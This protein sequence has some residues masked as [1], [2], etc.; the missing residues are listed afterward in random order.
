[1]SSDAQLRSELDRLERELQ[2]ARAEAEDERVQLAHAQ[3]E[4]VGA[5][6]LATLGSLVAG[7][8]H[9]LNTPLGSLHSNHDVL[10]RALHR[11]QDVLADEKVDEHELEEVRRIV[12]AL[13][14]VMRVNDLAVERMIKLVASLRTFGRPDRSDR[15]L[16]DVHDGIESALAILSHQLKDRITVVRKYGQLP[17]IDCYPNQLNQVWMNLLV[18][19]AQAITGQGSITI[20]TSAQTPGKVRVSVA[21]SG[22]GI[23]RENLRRIFEPGF[24]TKDGRIGM[25]LGLLIVR[26]IIERH[27]GRINVE[28]EVGTGSTFSIELPTVLPR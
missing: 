14:G 11:L 23:P 24:T 19:A 27:S 13:D 12:R 17:P 21:D 22:V 5:A 25:G 7:I 18:N 2:S 4:L 20:Q 10:K 1:V 8:A 3:A 16:I 6:K 28:S 15:D 26:Q 9:E